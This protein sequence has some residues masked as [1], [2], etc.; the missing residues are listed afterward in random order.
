MADTTPRIGMCTP[1]GIADYIEDIAPGIVLATTPSHG[2]IWLS[3]AR[4]DK[5]PMSW[6]AARFSGDPNSHWFEED[7]DWAMVALTFPAAFTPEHI[8]TA[9]QTY[10]HWLAPKAGPRS[11]GERA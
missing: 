2:G 10:D 6:R 11:H 4:L 8:E 3:T 5:V 9:R 7:C 1:W